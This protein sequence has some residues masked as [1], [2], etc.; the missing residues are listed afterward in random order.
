MLYRYRIVRPI[1]PALH[2]LHATYALEIV[3]Q[4]HHTIPLIEWVFRAR[5]MGVGTVC[6]IVSQMLDRGRLLARLERGF[7]VEAGT[8]AERIMDRLTLDGVAERA[9]LVR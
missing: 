9:R 7:E 5:K 3:R 1:P 2:Y 8:P 4:P 6:D